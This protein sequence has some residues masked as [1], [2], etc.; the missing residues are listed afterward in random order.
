MPRFN[1][2]PRGVAMGMGRG[3]FRALRA[4][5]PRKALLRRVLRPSHLHLCTVGGTGGRAF[6]RSFVVVLGRAQGPPRAGLSARFGH[7]A[8]KPAPHIT[9]TATRKVRPA[10]ARSV[11]SL[12]P[13]RSRGG[14]RPP[15]GPAVLARAKMDPT[16]SKQNAFTGGCGFTTAKGRGRLPRR[17]RCRR[18]PR[19][20]RRDCVRRNDHLYRRRLIGEKISKPKNRCKSPLRRSY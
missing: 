16:S 15:S 17:W 10:A 2:R 18:A 19:R 1:S 6:G 4:I 8:S 20:A 7:G 13:V 3:K 11:R 12:A 14:S 5:S 9:S